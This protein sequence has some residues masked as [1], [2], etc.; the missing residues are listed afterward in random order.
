MV[1][2]IQRAGVVG[3][4]VGARNILR[5]MAASPYL[6]LQ[7]GADIDPGA[8]SH[9]VYPEARGYDSVEMLAKDADVEA[10]WVATPN[11]FHAPQ[12]LLLANT[13]KHVVVQ[14]PER[15]QV[16]LRD[17]GASRR[18][19]SLGP[20]GVRGPELA[21]RQPLIPGLTVVTRR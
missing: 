2:R 12:T 7:A 4:G 10:V 8:R 5:Q 21:C 16:Y 1:E 3:L 9:Q 17:R 20:L 6:E 14:K 15:R 13:G 11:R 18:R 19:G